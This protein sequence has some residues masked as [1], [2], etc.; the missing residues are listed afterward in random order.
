LSLRAAF[1][2]LLFA[3]LA[4]FGWAHLIDTEPEPPQNDSIEHL[5][6]LKLLSEVQNGPAAQSAAPANPHSNSAPGPPAKAAPSPDAKPPASAGQGAS[7][8]PSGG[9]APNQASTETATQAATR[10][11]AS[12]ESAQRCVTVGPFS[13][14]ERVDQAAGILQQRG[15]KLRERTAQSPEEGY[16]VYVGG[17]KSDSDEA[18][19]VRRLEQNG[20]PDAHAMPNSGKGRR[21]SVG[22][23][24]E[25][26]GAERRARTVSALGLR[27]D[28]EKRTQAT[29]EHWV[30]VDID[31]SSQ[32][33]PAE[34]LLALQ[35][36]GARLEI[37]E[38]PPNERA[39]EGGAL[40]DKTVART[41]PPLTSSKTAPPSSH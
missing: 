4:F 22:F 24:A 40:S 6:Q 14:P 19:V 35:E 36:I 32:S 29:N 3:N 2:L 12:P 21:V 7:A 11:S 34:G 16:W 26:D 31:S 15:F 18:A 9:S 10:S 37:K 41:E 39:A 25:R 38:C 13:D 23:F 28:I 17:L 5:P 20:V 1:L 27:A 30:D 33:L 8:G